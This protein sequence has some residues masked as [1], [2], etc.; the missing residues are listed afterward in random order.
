MREMLSESMRDKGLHV[1]EAAE[2]MEAQSLLQ[3]KSYD[4]LVT[5]VRLPGIDGL[6]LLR[7]ARDKTP[8]TPV[9]L[10]TAYGSVEKAVEAMREGAF[11]F[12][13]K[14][15]D[16]DHLLGLIQRAAENAKLRKENLLLRDRFR[17]QVGAPVI[18]GK[19][20][21]LKDALAKALRAARADTTI[22]LRGESGTGK[23][24]FARAVHHGSQRA[25][26]PFVIVNCAA[27][28]ETLLESELFGHEKGA[29]TGATSARAGKFELAHGGTLFL[30]EIGDLPPA[31]QAKILRALQGGEIERLGA[32]APMKV[33]VR[34]VAATNRH[35]EKAVA[36]G[37]FRED[38]YY[39]VSVFPIEIPPLRHRKEDIPALAAHFMGRLAKE[40]KRPPPVLAEA[41]L[42]LLTSHGWPGNV[43]ELQ[44]VLER[45]MIMCDAGQIGPDHLELPR[46]AGRGKHW[47]GE[48]LRELTKMAVWA[49][50]E[51]A[52]TA[53]MRISGGTKTT[54]ARLLGVSYKTLLKKLTEHGI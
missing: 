2:G 30:D 33:D 27:I 45:G 9:I 10:M 1:E 46:L 4:V 34:V 15:F 47:A 22:L 40:M 24:L 8:H 49:A 3:R 12:L 13:T 37:A 52:L 26:G 31:L 21:V 36:D 48:P 17:E 5:D 11:D 39:R 32:T 28:P 43:R 23:E 53:A 50:E 38:L 16:V 18:V 7:V 20:P 42:G 29:F 41:A 19:S 6:Q 35:L 51:D 14:P 54:A 44:N 25:D